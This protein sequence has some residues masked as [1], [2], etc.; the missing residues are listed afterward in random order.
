MNRITDR[1]SW[2][3]AAVLALVAVAAFGPAVA[4]HAHYHDFADQQARWGV[5]H[6]AD[7]LSNL[8][9]AATGLAGAWRLAVAQLDRVQRAL[10]ALACAGLLLTAACSSWYHLQPGDAGLVIDRLGMTVAFAGLLGLA[11]CHV[12]RRAGIATAVLVLVGAP[13]TLLV[14][15]AS[16]NLLPWAVLQ[17]GGMAL[18][19]ACALLRGHD[20]LP[21]RWELVIA[22]YALAKLFELGDHAIWE[23]T[24][25]WISGHSLKHLVA[26][27][28]VWPVLATWTPRPAGQNAAQQPLKAA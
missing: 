22:A 20:A 5:P 11:A 19:L 24:G 17:G 4:Q 26:A 10:G 2:L 3:L 9:F 18:L 7:V 21:I 8:A 14:F 15:A 16:G 12:S 25:Q 13:L 1:E 23:A 28:A 6:A 27:A